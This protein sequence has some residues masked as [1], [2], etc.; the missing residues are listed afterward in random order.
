MIDTSKIQSGFDVELQ[1]GRGWFLTAMLALVDNGAIVLP[2]DI[3]ITNVFIVDNP[4]VDLVIATSAGIEINATLTITGNQFTF[5]ADFNNTTFNIDLP[6]LGQL[7]GP[8]VLQK[9]IGDADHENV[10]A[11]L[12]NLDLRASSQAGNPLPR[13]EHVER[14]NPENA[15]SFLPLDQHIALGIADDTFTRFAN[16]IWHTELTDEDGNHPLPKPG[17]EQRGDW[18]VIS[19]SLN[20]NRIKFTLHGEVPIDLWP[21]AE[22]SLE[23]ELKPEIAD[24]K[25]TFSVKTDLDIDTGFW[26]DVLAFTIGALLG[27]LVGL[28]TGG[29]ILIP[30]FGVGAVFLLEL[31]E[32][33]VG[34][35]LE[36]KILAKDSNGNIIAGLTCENQIVQLAT[37][38]PSEGSFSIGV[39]DA[40]PSSLPVLIDDSDPLFLK[41]V[42]VE[43]VFSEI[44]L[45][46]NGLAVAGL[47][48]Q[49][50]LFQPK[51]ARLKNSIYQGEELKQLTYEVPS[52]NEEVTLDIEEV[53]ERLS[54]NTLSAPLRIFAPFEDPELQ[55]PAG[56]LCC[57]C[58]TP[59]EIR[60]EDS[61]VTRI[62]FDNGLEL[63]TADA[64]AL[65]DAAGIYLEG[66]QLI[67]PRDGNPY[68]RAPA[69]ETTADNFESLPEF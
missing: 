60:R 59:S 28:L 38:K 64:V 43:A 25:L 8:P 42:T 33:V 47:S 30:A 12:F 27:L 19:V 24:G 26:G 31:G 15:V 51:L 22:V 35:V 34:E 29:L 36:R 23:L 66:F 10:M 62:K 44:E 52:S 17:E 45:N 13:G 5:T 7:A 2:C 18:T 58:L 4:D 68:F 46:E 53:F 16:N 6:N 56:K 40:I 14:G 69:N 49:A 21:D 63:N 57:P 11:L 1:L 55:I 54:E 3:T 41:M 39:L 67:H 61:I 20:D 65:Q 50:D 9:V 32:F 48:L 37:S